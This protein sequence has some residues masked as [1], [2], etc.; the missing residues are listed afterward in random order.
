MR[1][2]EMKVLLCQTNYHPETVPAM[3]NCAQVTHNGDALYNVHTC[4]A[5]TLNRMPHASPTRTRASTSPQ[6]TN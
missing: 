3:M 1:E 6:H 5:M 4:M 2:T